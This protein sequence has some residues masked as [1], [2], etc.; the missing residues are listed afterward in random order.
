M[1]KAQEEQKESKIM[2][3]LLQSLKYQLRDLK[4]MNNNI[5]NLKLKGGLN[6]KK[7]KERQNFSPAHGLNSTP[8]K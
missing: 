4:A 7:K 8:S 1:N 2:N 6:Q 5:D 3:V